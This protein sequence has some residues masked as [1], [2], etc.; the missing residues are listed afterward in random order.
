MLS[1]GWVDQSGAEGP[2]TFERPGIIQPNQAAW[3]T[4]ISL[5]PTDGLPIGSGALVADIAGNPSAVY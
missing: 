1:D 3:T 5:R 4:A 2:K